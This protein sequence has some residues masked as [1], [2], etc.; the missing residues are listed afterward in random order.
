MKQYRTLAAI[1]FIL[2]LSWTLFICHAVSQV[3]F[4]QVERS[5][6]KW[7]IPVAKR[8]VPGIPDFVMTYM[9]LA[10]LID[11]TEIEL[12]TKIDSMKW[13]T[14]DTLKLYTSEGI[15][16]TKI[17]VSHPEDSTTVSD[18]PMLD[19]TMTGKNITGI[20]DTITYLATK[21]GLS[22]KQNTLIS[23]TNIKTV[24]S[25]SLLGSG[26]VSVGTVTGSGTTNYIPKWSSSTA[27]SN[28]ILYESSSKIG[29]NWASPSRTLGVFATPPPT[30]DDGFVLNDGT[31]ILL[32]GFTGSSYTYRSIP[33]LSPFLYSSTNLGFCSDGG[34]MSFHTSG[35]TKMTLANSGA[36][37]LLGLS[38]ASTRIATVSTSGEIGVG[39][40]ASTIHSGS[41]TTNKLAKWTGTTAL[42]DSQV[43]DDGTDVTVGSG[44]GSII[45]KT[46]T[47]GVNGVDIMRGSAVHTSINSDVANNT[48]NGT[49]FAHNINRSFSHINTALPG[50]WFDMGG[51]GVTNSGGI[52]FSMMAATT[53]T[54]SNLFSVK[55][56]GT[57]RINSLDTDLTAPTTSGTTKMVITDGNGDLSFGNIA[58]G[59]V[60]SIGITGSDFNI[61]GSP[62]TTSGNIGLEIATG[63][64]GPTELASTAVTAGSYTNLNATIDA[65]GR[66]TAA[67]NGT[68]GVT[69]LAAIGA[70]ANANGATISGSTL[71]LQPASASFGGVMT[72]GTQTIAG[73]KTFSYLGGAPSG[74][75]SLVVADPNGRLENLYGATVGHVPKWNGT[76]FTLQADATGA[77]G[78]TS[79]GGLTGAT[80][81]LAYAT[82][83]TTPSWLSTG[84]SHTFRLPAGATGEVL[85][86][87]SGDWR[88]GFPIS[89]TTTGTSGNATYNST[90]G[91]LNIPNYATGSTNDQYWLTDNN[92]TYHQIRMQSSDTPPANTD[93]STFRLAEGN[94]VDI[95]S[96]GNVATVNIVTTAV[97]QMHKEGVTTVSFTA[98][99][100]QKV[101]LT[102]SF[103]SGSGI[104]TSDANDRIT[105]TSAG[106]YMIT[107][108]LDVDMNATTFGLTAYVRVS[109]STD[110]SASYKQYNNDTNLTPLSKTFYVDLTAGQYIELWLSNSHTVSTN[111]LWDP[112]LTIQRVQ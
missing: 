110:L 112:I 16:K 81:T 94:G 17:L 98:V 85:K 12:G 2:F 59:T 49:L 67:A 48:Y 24:N 60:S 1:G 91:V 84:T 41:G 38:G 4:T 45:L 23:G 76:A 57:F 31:N 54:V 28:S 26:N 14:G 74:G 77:S 30:S 95:V 56:N 66:I 82:S 65:D 78:I 52:F 9:T 6:I 69:T 61:T 107:Y 44:G 8:V 108:S 25:N 92:T 97:G 40:A 102:T 11:S 79:L 75:N 101:A 90:T 35:G 37:T 70:T 43:T 63:V 68:A 93:V 15:F 103:T 19:L 3:K 88:P 73:A 105:V 33:A 99:T 106:K 20:P 21:Y 39:V 87:S 18:T 22:L 86:W 36:L 104:S 55:N 62:V 80:Q 29:V 71:N 13:S 89:L 83:G 53:S 47:A 64:V 42:G 32:F 50:Y 46:S 51:R 100:P 109:G 27:L 5:S 72:T 10:N 58:S 96:S 34:T 7:T 111:S